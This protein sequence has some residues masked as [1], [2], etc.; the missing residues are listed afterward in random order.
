MALRLALGAK[1]LDCAVTHGHRGVAVFDHA[2]AVAPRIHRFEFHSFLLLAA[3]MKR[4][5][6]KFLLSFVHIHAKRAAISSMVAAT[7]VWQYNVAGSSA[8]ISWH[9][10]TSAS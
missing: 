2:A 8:S 7:G 1:Q 4:K 5:L 9:T 10:L 6:S 3:A